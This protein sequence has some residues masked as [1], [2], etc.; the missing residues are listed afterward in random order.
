RYE[1]WYEDYDESPKIQIDGDI[2]D[3]V[4]VP[5]A[6]QYVLALIEKKIEVLERLIKRSKSGLA[7]F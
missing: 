1:Q 5:E 6:C 3:F 4:E 2:Y 7:C